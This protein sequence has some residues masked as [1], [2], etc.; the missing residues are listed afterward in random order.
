MQDDFITTN[1]A[2]KILGVKRWALRNYAIA[3]KLTK[4]KAV[5]NRQIQYKRADI[6]AL[7]V[8]QLIN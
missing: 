7:A 3:G 6:E 1:E 5:N 2:M 8:P 4:Y